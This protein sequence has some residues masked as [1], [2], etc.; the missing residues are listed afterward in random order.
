MLF[1]A[2]F[3]DFDLQSAGD[4]CELKLAIIRRQIARRFKAVSRQRTVCRARTPIQIISG[5]GRAGVPSDNI[6]RQSSRRP[7]T[8]YR[9]CI[10]F[11]LYGHFSIITRAAHTP[12]TSCI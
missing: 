11:S 12:I 6:V 2:V 5:A 4:E 8:Q 7:I 3:D 1:L 10:G 9:I